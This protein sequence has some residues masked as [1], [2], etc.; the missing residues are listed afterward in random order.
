MNKNDIKQIIYPDLLQKEDLNDVWNKLYLRNI[1]KDYKLFFPKGAALGE[2]AVF[3]IKFFTY[4]RSAFYLD[5]AGYHYR[6]VSGSA[7]RDIIAKDYFKRELEVYCQHIEEISF[8]G[9]EDKKVQ[10]LKSIKLVNN[11]LSYIYIYFKP[12]KKVSFY[13]RYKYVKN[14]ITNKK[15]IEALKLCIDE[16]NIT[17]G[18]YDKFIIKMA[19][20]KFIAVIYFATTYSRLRNEV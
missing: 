10:K 20:L 14:M 19:Q 4:A 17:K 11:V 16:L 6:E 3:N 1:I 2:D 7:T 18:R 5:Y 9:I 15:F 8:W 13:S 12:N